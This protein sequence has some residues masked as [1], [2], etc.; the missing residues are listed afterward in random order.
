M[1]QDFFVTLRKTN[2]L[3]DQITLYFT[4]TGHALSNFWMETMQDNFLSENNKSNSKRLNKSFCFHAWQ[5]EWDQ[6][7]YSRNLDVLSELLN[8]AIGK[9]NYYYNPFGYPHIDIHY[10]K[11]NLQDLDWYRNAM[12]ELHHHFELLIGQVGN[13][14][15][16][17]YKPKHPESRY[18]VQELN[19]LLHEIEATVNNILQGNGE[20]CIL[21]NYN[22][23]R[24]DGTYAPEPVRYELQAE[25]YDCFEDTQHQWGM[26]TAYYSQLGKQHIEVYIDGDD[27]IH[28]ENISGIQYMLGECILN[29]GK[30]SPHEFPGVRL[31][32]KYTKWLIDNGIDPN[33]KTLALGLGVL[34]KLDPTKNT[35]LGSTWKEIDATIHNYD[36]VYE[37]GFVDE[38]RDITISKCYDYTWKDFH[39]KLIESYKS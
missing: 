31:T 16:W 20:K 32:K 38:N 1:T 33:D 13:T 35:H 22:G 36:D 4:P 23:P 24:E 37:L 9:V 28:D 3:E 21:L 14:S 8:T 39:N 11:E 15:D 12:N 18:Y 5:A 6:P 19:N 27:V 10:S 34:A 2:Q 17:Y 7:N 29:F 26:I 30:R 25:H